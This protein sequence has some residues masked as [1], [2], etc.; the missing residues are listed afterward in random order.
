MNSY[1]VD[2]VIGRTAY[3]ILTEAKEQCVD[4]H[5]VHVEEY[6]AYEVGGYA[7]DYRWDV[8]VVQSLSLRYF[9]HEVPLQEVVH[10]ETDTDGY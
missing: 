7:E 5:C 2:L 4:R 1:A 8:V 6:C 10:S 9:I 3:R